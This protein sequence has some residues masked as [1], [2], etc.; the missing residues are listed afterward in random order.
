M[1]KPTE[2][3]SHE[4]AIRFA[5]RC[6]TSLELYS[7]RD[8]FRSLADTTS[9]IHYWREDTLCRFLEIPDALGVGPVIHQ[10]AAYLGAF[11]FPSLAPSILN[12]E[13]LLKV[14]VIMTERY[15]RV[16]KRGKTDRIRLLFRSLAVF[17]RRTSQYEDGARKMEKDNQGERGDR[18]EGAKS[19]QEE[20]REASK[21]VEG[22]AIDDA[23]N[24]EDEDEDDDELALAALESLDAIEVF[25]HGEK[26]N[27]NH[28]QIPTDNFRRLIMLLIVTAP[29][30]AQESLSQHAD[31]FTDEKLE[32]LKR[33]ADNILW[34][35]GV[36]KHP[37]VLYHSFNTII[38][39]SLVGTLPCWIEELHH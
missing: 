17:D 35:F 27:I 16:L 4:L 20:L 36:E 24:D 22:F 29:L 12:F 13:A 11:P 28:A 9:D 5:K 2:Q 32:G 21:G 15:G 3:L 6:F 1:H 14:V 18:E 33:T 38:P 31:R 23:A 25:K 8:V 34:A 7:F 30:D 10:S 39:V 19:F 37:G 26:S